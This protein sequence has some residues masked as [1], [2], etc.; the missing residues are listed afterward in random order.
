MIMELVTE[1]RCQEFFYVVPAA[2]NCVF[3]FM[4]IRV[5]A[6]CQQRDTMFWGSFNIHNSSQYV[7]RMMDD[8]LVAIYY[9]TVCLAT[10]RASVEK[11]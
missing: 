3:P 8:C 5:F 6:V 10:L 9:G 4:Y 1:T 11:E 7:G 2:R